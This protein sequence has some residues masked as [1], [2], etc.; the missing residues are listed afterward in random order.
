MDNFPACVANVGQIQLYPGAFNIVPA[1]AVLALECRAADEPTQLQLEAELTELAQAQADRFGLGLEIEF[2]GRHLPQPMSLHFQQA[3]SRAA[4]G[5]S[6][7][8]VEL[9]SGAGHDAQSLASFCPCGM[10]F[11]PSV[12]G[13][14]HAP[15]EY[16]PWDDCVNGANVLLHTLLYLTQ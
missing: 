16:T 2:L 1:K 3:I 6:L 5:L 15:D 9:P 11:V 8:T 12:D 7:K 13:I 4:H 14:S 10:I